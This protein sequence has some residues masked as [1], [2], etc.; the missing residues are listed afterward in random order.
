MKKA[1]GIL[2]VAVFS[3]V[4]FLNTDVTNGSNSDLNLASLGSLNT[5]SASCE[6]WSWPQSCNSF[7][8]CSSFGSGGG[9]NI[10]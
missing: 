6:M 8:R 2:S 1:I 4:M 7:D 9:C 3:A 5:A 10:R